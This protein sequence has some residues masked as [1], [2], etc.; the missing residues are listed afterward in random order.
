MNISGIRQRINYGVKWR[1]DILRERIYRLTLP[2]RAKLMRRKK[3]INV[4]FLVN[5][6]P[7][8]KT[9]NLFVAM[10]NHP[11]FNPIV[12][13][14]VA[15][16][17]PMSH[18]EVEDYCKDKGYPY[19]I[20]DSDKRIKPQTRADIVF[21]L[22]PYQTEYHPCHRYMENLDII[23]MYVFYS[24]HGIIDSAVLNK[25][26]YRVL[27]YDFY[28]NRLS[29]EDA[30]AES[31]NHGKNFCVT[32]LPFADQLLE[33]KTK[34]PD[35]WRDQLSRKR[36]I[37]A[38]HHTIGGIHMKGC[39]YGTF[40]ETGE[41]MLELAKKYKNQVFF[42]FKPHPLLW[43][44]LTRIWPESRV[45]A[46]FREWQNLEN[47]QYENGPYMGLFKHSDAMIH[48]CSS[49]IAEYIAMDKPVM[50][51]M[52]DEHT[53]DNLNRTF[54]YAHKLHYQGRTREDIERFIQMV[55]NNEDP[56][57]IERKG[58]IDECLRP[59]FGKSACANIINAILA[60]EE[61]SNI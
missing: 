39:D 55:I 60:K 53:V 47:A 38:P 5:D 20:L 24:F 11:R 50:F 42:A 3:I 54:T 14:P 56:K 31:W 28:D 49:F 41:I 7:T 25:P 17:R 4:T 34:T 26:M 61:Y 46:Y 44:R 35:Q 9:E 57:A 13:I 30:K 37:Y 29:A 52:K 43:Q 21:Y 36:I 10:Q 22:K 18:C 59:P 8:W 23:H 32:G 12:G 48:D 2:V 6:L 45:A 27:L 19:I 33:E 58:F 16:E 40:L 51:L 1:F 15:I